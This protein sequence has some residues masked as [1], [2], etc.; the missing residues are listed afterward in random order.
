M[1]RVRKLTGTGDYS[2]GNSGQDF[3]INQPEVVGQNVK[4][5]LLLWLGEWYL[6]INQGTPY[7]QGILGKYSQQVADTIIQDQV[8]GT[9]G[10]TGIENFQSTLD[11]DARE[12]LITFDLNTIFGPTAVQIAN[13]ANY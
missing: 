5:R 1:S 3:Y 10:V 4:T 9:E 13:Y 12:L 11:P 8:L 6:D 2:F 7:M